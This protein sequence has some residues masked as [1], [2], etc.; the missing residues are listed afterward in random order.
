MIPTFN[1]GDTLSRCLAPL[2][3]NPLAREIIVADGGSEDGTVA[4][5]RRS[6]GWNGSS[7]GGRGRWA[8]RMAT[9]DC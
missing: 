4:V 5:A 3:A 6:G 1:V 8:C 7:P 2:A 9:R